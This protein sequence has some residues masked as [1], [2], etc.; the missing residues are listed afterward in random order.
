MT[1]TIACLNFKLLLYPTLQ[2]WTNWEE[3]RRMGQLERTKELAMEIAGLLMDVQANIGVSRGLLEKAPFEPRGN[4]E[5]QVRLVIPEIG[6]FTWFV[7]G[8]LFHGDSLFAALHGLALE[9]MCAGVAVEEVLLRVDQADRPGVAH[10]LHEGIMTGQRCTMEYTVCSGGICHRV[11]AIGCCLRND[12]G[13]PSFFS[14]IAIE[15]KNELF[16]DRSD[17]FRSYCDAAMTLAQE[18]GNLLA[19]RYLRSAINSAQQ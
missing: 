14:G 17:P 15:K 5:S 7:A 16:L 11:L 4:R 10:T 18:R 13:L 12:Q 6:F 8:N 2:I 1:S 9:D 3:D 19:E